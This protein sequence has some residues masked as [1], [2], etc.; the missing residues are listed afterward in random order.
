[1]RPACVVVI[2]ACALAACSDSR[3]SPPA[4]LETGAASPSAASGTPAL[5]APC[6]GVVKNRELPSWART[7]GFRKGARPN[8]VIGVN[9]KLAGVLFGYPLYAPPRPGKSNK[10]LWIVRESTLK[11]TSTLTIKA[12][13]R[14]APELAV[15]RSVLYRPGS[16]GLDLP[17]AGC[18]RF[19]I[20]WDGGADVVTIPYA[21]P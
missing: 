13:L 18:W 11:T 8:H 12:S 1:M 6:P 5:S 3:P 17:R 19:E 10:I 20:S 4:S 9:K 7:P 21:A 2:F 15:T 14:E 16:S